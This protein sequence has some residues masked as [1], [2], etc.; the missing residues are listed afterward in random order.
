MQ[1]IS[2]KKYVVMIPSTAKKEDLLDLKNFM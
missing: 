1:N 2:E